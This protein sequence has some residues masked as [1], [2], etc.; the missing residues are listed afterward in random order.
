MVPVPDWRPAAVALGPSGSLYVSYL[1]SSAIVRVV[2]PGSGSP[3]IQAVGT[4]ST[5]GG[6]RSLAFVGNDLY[7]AESTGVTRIGTSPT[8]TANSP[9]KSMPSSS[10]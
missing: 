4:S 5:G 1:N 6:V 9:S 8:M 3:T 7:L 10:R 2:G